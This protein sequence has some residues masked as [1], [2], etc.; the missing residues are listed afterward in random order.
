MFHKGQVCA[1]SPITNSIR[2]LLALIYLRWPFRDGF[3][4]QGLKGFHGS[5][6]SCCLAGSSIPNKLSTPHRKLH[7]EDLR[8]WIMV[9][10]TK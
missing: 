5:V 2:E 3:I 8:N 9:P 4:A 7:I 6:V 10:G 1:D